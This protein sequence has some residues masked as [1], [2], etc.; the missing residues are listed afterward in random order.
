MW[1]AA[2]GQLACSGRSCFYDWIS[3]YCRTVVGGGLA[4]VTGDNCVMG[5]GDCKAGSIP[6]AAG[7]MAGPLAASSIGAA[8]TG[9]LSRGEP[10]GVP[11]AFTTTCRPG[12]GAAITGEPAIELFML[13]PLGIRL[14]VV[15]PGAGAA[16]TRLIG[17]GTAPGKAVGAAKPLE[18]AMLV[19]G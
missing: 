13:D 9:R 10:L 15:D 6:T 12:A 4:S 8:G 19:L 17:A 11:T 3:R 1:P 18:G 7:G 2:A 5:C 16:G 14:D